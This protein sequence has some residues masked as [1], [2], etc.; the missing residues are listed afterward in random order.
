MIDAADRVFY[1]RGVTFSFFSCGRFLR[2]PAFREIGLYELLRKSEIPPPR[3]FCP[4]LVTH[5]S[6]RII[7]PSSTRTS[8]A[9]PVASASPGRLPRPPSSFRK[10]PSPFFLRPVDRPKSECGPG[11]VGRSLTSAIP[12]HLY[13]FLS[14]SK[15]RRRF[16]RSL[17]SLFLVSSFHPAFSGLLLR[18]A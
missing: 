2:T 1:G 10:R 16:P 8:R 17:P 14:F 11:G 4:R 18:I 7:P 6:R 3:C 13:K 15:S 5:H 12:F 9:I